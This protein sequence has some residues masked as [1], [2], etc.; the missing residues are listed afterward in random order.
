MLKIVFVN[1][2]AV[3]YQRYHLLVVE[4]VLVVHQYHLIGLNFDYLRQ[5]LGNLLIFSFFR[6]LALFALYIKQ[7]YGWLTL[8]GSSFLYFFN[9]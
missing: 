5:A 6:I 1:R 3:I 7:F 9:K 4:A 8:Q 2:L